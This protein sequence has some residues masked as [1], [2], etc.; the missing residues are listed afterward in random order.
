MSLASDPP[1]G[2]V[3]SAGPMGRLIAATDWSA[4]PIGPMHRWPEMLRVSLAVILRSPLPMA[5]LWG[6]EAQLFYNDAFSRFTAGGHP[7][8]LGLAVRQTWPELAALHQ[9]ALSAGMRGQPLS[10]RE[11]L[12]VLQRQGHAQDVWVDMDFSPL[13]SPAGE[14]LGILAVLREITEHVLSEW[15]RRETE[16]QLAL[17][18][19]ATQLGTW[20]LDL[21]TGQL[22]CSEHCRR[23]FGL[24]PDAPVSLDV[25]FGGMHPADSDRV[26]AALS[27]ALDPELRELLDVEYRTIGA[28][29]NVVRWVATRGRAVFNEHG[30][31]LRAIGT[32]LDI[33]ARKNAELRQNHL[34]EL[35]DRFRSLD[36]TAEIAAVASEILGRALN[37]SR[38]GYAVV[39]GDYLTV[40]CD[41]TD[42]QTLSVAGPRP[43]SALGEAFCAPLRAGHPVVINN[44]ATDPVTAE[45]RRIFAEI[46]TA[47]LMKT[48]LL[49]NGELVSL[50]YIHQSTP[51]HWTADEITLL[52]DI[53]DRTWEASGRANA[54][55]ALRNFNETLEQQV[56]YRTA[57]RDRM[58]K[59]S[60]DVML[61]AGLD[62]VIESVN[63]AWKAVFGWNETDLVG[64]NFISLTHPDDRPAT[65]AEVQRLAS[66]EPTTKFENRYRRRDGSYLWLSWRAVP[67]ANAIHAVGR[68]ITAE[69]EQ[70]EALR[71]AEEQLRQA[72]K[73]E[74]VG[75]LTGGIA[76]DFNNL[77]Q[78]IVGA[79]D[80]LDKRIAQGNTGEANKFIA[81]AR[82]SANRAAALTHRLLAFSRR[83]PL[84]P[85][86]VQANPLV[87]SMEDLLR[88]TIG[89]TI[90]L[91]LALASNLWLTRCDPNQLESAILN[92]AINARDAMPDGGRLILETTNTTLD[93]AYTA[94]V[95]EVNPGDYICL[96]VSDTGTGMPQS[97]VEQ[98]FEPFYTTKPTGQGTGLGLSMVYGFS[99]QSE[100]HARIYSER[101]H[102]TTVKIYLPRFHGVAATTA[103]TAA[104]PATPQATDGEIV[105]VV[106]DEAVV[107]GLVVEVLE[108]LG[109]QALQAADGAAGLEIL[110]STQHIDLLVTDI[111]LPGLNG[112]QIADAGRLLRPNLKILFMTGYAE[113]AATAAGF[114]EPGMAM[115]TKPFPIDTLTDRVRK[116]LE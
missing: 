98:A 52:K 116:M 43:F 26:R 90:D 66:G 56:A 55:Q 14:C 53:A 91:T 32:T 109:Y 28:E 101:N 57:Q 78:G 60:S 106:E 12:L 20:N 21:I 42:G 61:V 73:M 2:N 19:D 25:S 114:L 9:Q 104:T 67:D 27:R 24:S 63:P 59:L 36:T 83:Q 34:I 97:V 111:G 64:R 35:G 44:V 8:R 5:V 48:P 94:R 112:R 18:I 113:T 13:A 86:P 45:A 105:L 85:K 49:V 95:P 10:L 69:R 70:A 39:H 79:L 1:D 75:Q 74:A 58:W 23:A 46:G 88:R 84:D 71:A 11:E 6:P 40:E 54:A 92:L 62:A 31:G 76:H 72:Q 16:N 68:D 37:G 89:E 103:A 81:A 50:L 47:A 115:I 110:R 82:L 38:A 33:T 80:L 7:Q 99:K 22:S 87:L 17:A 41:W 100:G 96:S 93:A 15:R 102:G 77:L 51:R 29:D 65:R 4:S 3:Q 107:R 30:R 108:D